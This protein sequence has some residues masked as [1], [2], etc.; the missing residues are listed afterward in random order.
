[1]SGSFG[2]LLQDAYRRVTDV[3][4]LSPGASPTRRRRYTQGLATIN[5][6]VGQ[7]A[8]HVHGLIEASSDGEA[9]NPDLH[10]GD[11]EWGERSSL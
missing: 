11:G 9:G 4:P 1:M 7:M 3:V 10:H 2:T 5:Q 6:W 8:A